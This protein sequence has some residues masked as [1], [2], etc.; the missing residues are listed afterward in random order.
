KDVDA[1][2][3][4]GHDAFLHRAFPSGMAGTSP[5]MTE[6]SATTSQ[7]F[8]DGA[9]APDPES[10]CR[11][12]ARFWIPGSQPS[13]APRNDNLPPS[14]LELHPGDGLEI[15][16]PDLFLVGLRHVDAFDDA[17]GFARVHRALLRIERAVG[18]EHDLVEVVE[19]E[20][21]MRRRHATEHRRVGIE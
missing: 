8:R 10:R 11:H 14:A 16:V 4:C 1:R 15:A 5:A 2:N 12:G 17:Q 21:R 7:S 9:S 13:A 20:A 3:K 19:G 18:S 6:K